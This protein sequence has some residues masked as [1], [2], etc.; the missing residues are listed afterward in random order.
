MLDET[1]LPENR[2]DPFAALSRPAAV[3]F[4]A[5]EAVARCFKREEMLRQMIQFFFR[6]VDDLFP[7]MRA[8][9]KRGDLAEVGRLGHRMKGTVVYLAAEPATEAAVHVERFSTSATGTAAEAEEAVDA[10][11]HECRLLRTALLEHP[12]A[13]ERPRRD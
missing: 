13:V 10:L 12:L 8:A 6:E 1:N 2:S 11:E 5:E 7:Q 9:L 4:N 3:V